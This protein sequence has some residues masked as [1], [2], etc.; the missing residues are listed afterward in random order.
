MIWISKGLFQY[1]TSP[2]ISAGFLILLIILIS[3][4]AHKLIKRRIDSELL[5]VLLLIGEFVSLYLIVS[6]SWATV[7]RYWYV[8][9]PVFTTLLAI[10]SRSILEF[11]RKNY[12]VLN[13][14]SAAALAT[15]VMYFIGCNY[16][17]FLLQTIAQHSLRQAEFE[18]INEISSLHDQGHYVYIL[19]DNADPDAELLHHIADYY[20]RFSPR[21][22]G[23]HYEIHTSPPK[24]SDFPYFL[25]SRRKKPEYNDIY[26]HIKPENH[27]ILL[28]YAHKLSGLFLQKK[29]INVKDAGVHRING[30]EWYIYRDST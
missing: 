21:F 22:H 19:V 11:T 27:Y 3:S 9:I 12:T 1:K 5:F 8:L 29:P 30:Y 16:Y 14:V 6:T 4:G 18:L 23:K 28:N 25:V 2:F 10:S 17:N 24:A 15:F 13:R 7:L 20:R 26:K